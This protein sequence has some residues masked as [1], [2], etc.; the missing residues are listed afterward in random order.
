AAPPRAG[1]DPGR[2]GQRRGR[3][4]RVRRAGR[5]A[6]ALLRR[7]R[8]RGR[9]GRGR[10]L[11]GLPRLPRPLVRRRPGP[12]LGPRRPEAN[13]TPVTRKF[14]AAAVDAGAP[15]AAFVAARLGLDLAAARRRVEEGA[16]Y[17]D[18]RRERDP[19][20]PLRA[21]ARVAVHTPA[22][23]T[24]GWR[25]VYRDAEVLVVDKPAGLPVAAARAGGTALDGEVAARFPGARPL[26]RLARDTSGLVLFALGPAG[27]R[28]LAHDLAA[29][30]LER[31]YLAVVAGAPPDRATLDAVIGPDPA[32]R[33]RFRA[34]VPGG[35]PARTEIRVV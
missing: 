19:G 15:L 10:R 32:D 29:G 9:R 27:R 23:A 25:E 1:A 34:G 7:P 11:A 31:V 12:P 13:L 26:H 14:R 6:R 2:A 28:R 33:R 21:G 8:R 4:A 16:V 22:A 17:V 24:Q 20:L 3:R 35:R 18:G 5:R 30:R